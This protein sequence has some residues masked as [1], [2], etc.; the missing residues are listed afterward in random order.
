MLNK[1]TLSKKSQKAIDRILEYTYRQFGEKQAINYKSELENCL[2]LLVDNPEI[3]HPCNQIREGYQRH[4][5]QS[6]IIFYPQRKN[7][8]FISAIIHKSRDLKR[9]L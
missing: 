1:Y 4:E 8:I 3:G 2:Q 5:H 9:H 6:H 7:D